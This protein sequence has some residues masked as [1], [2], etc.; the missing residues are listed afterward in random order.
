MNPTQEQDI[1]ALILQLTN[2]RNM[3]EEE[4]TQ[5]E[6]AEKRAMRAEQRAMRAE[7]Q[8]AQKDSYIKDLQ[9]DNRR[10]RCER[11]ARLRARSCVADYRSLRHLYSMR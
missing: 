8:V 7:Q 5:R 10:L 9:D 6:D 3:R 11:W 2:E 1:A 4:R